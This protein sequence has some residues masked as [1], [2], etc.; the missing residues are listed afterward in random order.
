MNRYTVYILKC[1]GGLY[2]TDVTNDIKRRVFEHQSG[3]NKKSFTY[4]RRPV[5]LVF[6]EHFHDINQAITFEKQVKGWRRA[7]KE[8]LIRRDWNSLPVLSKRY[9]NDQ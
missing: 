9:K 1:A 4:R 6:Q 5:K 7:K 8:A 2:Y 3:F